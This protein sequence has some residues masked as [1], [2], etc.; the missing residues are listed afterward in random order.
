MEVE[1]HSPSDASGST[2]NLKRARSPPSPTPADRPSKRQTYASEGVTS[3]VPRHAYSPAPAL[4]PL[5]MPPM[6]ASDPVYSAYASED[7]VAQTRGLRIDSPHLVQGPQVGFVR[8][9]G[10]NRDSATLQAHIDVHMM[11]SD[12]TMGSASPPR[13]FAEPSTLGFQSNNRPID[14][15]PVQHGARATSHLLHPNQQQQQQ[16]QQQLQIP[17]IQVHAATPS[18]I[19]RDPSASLPA[20]AR[21]Q[22]LTMGPRAD[23]EKCRMGVKGHYVHVD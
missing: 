6:P 7:W 2:K 16:Q 12:V 11:D 19:H 9:P 17:A 14:S 20:A 18:P 15:L 22:R 5:I 4:A 10:E 3:P 13:R 23:C 8:V 21:R 1:M